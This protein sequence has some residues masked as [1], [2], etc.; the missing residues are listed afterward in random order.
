MR[1]TT[2][3]SSLQGCCIHLRHLADMCS[4]CSTKLIDEEGDVVYMLVCAEG[5]GTI[6]YFTVFR[7]ECLKAHSAMTACLL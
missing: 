7:K 5:Y 2:M 1:V 6:L 4:S 3:L